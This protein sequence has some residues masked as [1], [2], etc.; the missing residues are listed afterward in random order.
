VVKLKS[1]RTVFYLPSR[2]LFKARAL[3]ISKQRIIYPIILQERPFKHSPSAN[4]LSQNLQG[5]IANKPHYLQKPTFL[6]RKHEKKP[7]ETNKQFK[8]KWRGEKK[9]HKYLK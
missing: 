6:K 7:L 1:A 4:P 9:L 8:G 5:P 2:I 3:E